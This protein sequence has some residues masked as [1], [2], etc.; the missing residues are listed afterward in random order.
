MF[1]KDADFL[2]LFDNNENLQLPG[3]AFEYLGTTNP[4]ITIT[5]NFNSSLCELMREVDRFRIA[6]SKI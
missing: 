1:M 3:K 4:I 2:I 5:T 6:S